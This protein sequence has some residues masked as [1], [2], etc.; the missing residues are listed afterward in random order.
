MQKLPAILRAI[1]NLNPDEIHALQSLMTRWE[2]PAG[3][4]DRMSRS[5]EEALNQLLRRLAPVLPKN[6]DDA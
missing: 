5:E 2:Q 6:S 1:K 3:A 4:G